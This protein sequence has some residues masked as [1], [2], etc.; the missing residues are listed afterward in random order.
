MK[1]QGIRVLDLSRFLPGPMLTQHMA[2]HGAEVIKIESPGE[3]EPTRH[4]GEKRDGVTV[5]FANTQRGRQSVVLNLKHPEAREAFMR[6]A[7]TADVIVEGF[8][9]GVAERIGVGYAQVA[10][11][12]PQVVYAS[13]SSY[14]QDGP[15]RDIATHDL[16][17]EA[18]A[19]VLSLTRGRDGKPSIPGFPASDVISATMTLAGVLMALLRRRDSGRGDYLDM[20]MA[21]CML[22]SIPNN[23]GAAMAERRQ[24]DPDHERS[25]G[26]NALY[27][28][29]E[30]ADAQWIALGSQEAKF[31]VT[32]LTGLGR[33]DLIEIASGLP[34]PRQAPVRAFL[35]ETFRTRTR[36]E[37]EAWFAGR[38]FP[39]APVK[40]LPEALDDPH[41]R[42]R[43]MVTTDARGWDHIGSPIRFADEPARPDFSAA[44]P[45]QHTAAVL[46]KVGYTP[47]DIERLAQAGAIGLPDPAEVARYAG[48]ATP[49]VSP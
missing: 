45:G 46:A 25:L 17:T 33:P 23:L 47:A 4:I 26:G 42:A 37:W 16:A 13:I 9:P 27:R 21:E 20:S 39:F 3:G 34:G 1:L 5:Y 12:A 49:S 36:A 40:S 2:D 14:G 11:R 24:I 10:K 44:A 32:L 31:V 19:G 48:T 43:G 7:E 18:M 8:R 6:L 38:D 30:T 22:T 15:Y 41:F 35:E 29:Y 28:L